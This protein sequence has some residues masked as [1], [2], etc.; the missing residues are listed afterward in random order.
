MAKVINPGRVPFKL[1]TLHVVPAGG[2]VELSN[3]ALREC[4]RSI[5]GIVSIGDLSV[6]W[7]AEEPEPA[8]VQPAPRPRKPVAPDPAP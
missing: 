6:E 4:M 5:S 1:P 2:S 8:P 7:D 3:D